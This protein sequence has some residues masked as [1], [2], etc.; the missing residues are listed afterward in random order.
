MAFENRFSEQLTS[1][2][3]LFPY[4][5][6]EPQTKIVQTRSLLSARTSPRCAR[7]FSPLPEQVAAM[8][9]QAAPHMESTLP[10]QPI[11][12]MK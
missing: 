4:R 6:L 10:G 5:A 11:E 1:F 12:N 8:A 9:L 3:G 7:A 2:G